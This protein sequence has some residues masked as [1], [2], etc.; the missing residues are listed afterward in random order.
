MLAVTTGVSSLVTFDPNDGRAFYL[1]K[2][3]ALDLGP[4]QIGVAIPKLGTLS[5][6][7][8]VQA[9]LTQR[10]TLY[11]LISG[12]VR[13]ADGSTYD[14]PMRMSMVQVLEPGTHLWVS[15]NAI[16]VFSDALATVAPPPPP[17][18]YT[19]PPPPPPPS[20]KLGL[21]LAVGALTAALTGGLAALSSKPRRL[22]VR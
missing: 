13:R 22:G 1:A 10:A 4:S 11:T 20:M 3:I 7:H 19:P 6:V 17:L 5:N 18:S 15:R 2:G 12:T 9:K 16:A 14:V 8:L 21:A